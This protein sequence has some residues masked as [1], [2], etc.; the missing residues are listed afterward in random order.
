MDLTSRTTVYGT[1]LETPDVRNSLY[2]MMFSQVLSPSFF[3]F[4][5]VQHCGCLVRKSYCHSVRR[6]GSPT[7]NQEYFS[8]FLE[9]EKYMFRT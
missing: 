5:F 6:R 7:T 2:W 1:Q 3:F 8:F 4:F 9:G